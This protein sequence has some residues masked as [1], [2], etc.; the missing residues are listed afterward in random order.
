M[1]YQKKLN[2]KI[3]L[4]PTREG[5]KL[6]IAGKIQKNVEKAA[7]DTSAS[8]TQAKIQVL[9]KIMVYHRHLSVAS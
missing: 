9:Q 4:N 5:E 3:E 7:H 1:L 6:T 2:E 8:E